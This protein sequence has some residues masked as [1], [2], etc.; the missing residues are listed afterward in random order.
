M[1]RWT[2]GAI[3]ALHPDATRE[4]HRRAAAFWHWRVD[5]IPQSREQDIEQLLEARYHHH[6]AGDTDEALAATR[7]P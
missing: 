2:A 5:T 6:A 3:A 1:H 4:A 7:K